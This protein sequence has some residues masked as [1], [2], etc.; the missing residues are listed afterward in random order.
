M[1]QHRH[2]GTAALA[3]CSLA[4]LGCPRSPQVFDAMAMSPADAALGMLRSE[5]TRLGDPTP[6]DVDRLAQ[7]TRDA[8]R[9]VFSQGQKQQRWLGLS[10]TA[11]TF[12]VKTGQYAGGGGAIAFGLNAA[13]K[14]DDGKQKQ[15]GRNAAWAGTVAASVTLLEQ[16]FNLYKR[17]AREAACKELM[18][19]KM[20]FEGRTRL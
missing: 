20:D 16:L 12:V 19:R 8:L 18:L 11:G 2:A 15:A 5:V 14:D 13:Q 17:K 7:S 9:E 3:L 4:V 6:E 1:R 10:T